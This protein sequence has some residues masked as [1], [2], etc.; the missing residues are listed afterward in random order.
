MNLLE[1]S[2]TGALFAIILSFP[3][4]LVRLSTMTVCRKGNATLSRAPV[5]V[6][7][8]IVGWWVGVCPPSYRSL[9]AIIRVF[10]GVEWIVHRTPCRELSKHTR[11]CYCKISK[12]QRNRQ[13]HETVMRMH[14]SL[15]LLPAVVIHAELSNSFPVRIFI[16][17][18]FPSALSVATLPN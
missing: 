4:N 12:C 10:M 5:V 1:L 9:Y 3:P 6:I 2:Y 13:T 15:A 7:L 18:I 14:I 8:G 11:L 17:N 16:L